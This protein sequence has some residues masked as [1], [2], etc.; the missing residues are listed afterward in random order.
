MLLLLLLLV[1]H[2][3]DYL[4]F[5]AGIHMCAHGCRRELLRNSYLWTLLIPTL[6][7]DCLLHRREVTTSVYWLDSLAEGSASNVGDRSAR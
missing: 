5:L 3:A 1:L 4:S 2:S 7:Q 6:L